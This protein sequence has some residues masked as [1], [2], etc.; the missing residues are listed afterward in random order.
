VTP[1]SWGVPA[2]NLTTESKLFNAA[3]KMVTLVV[4][5]GVDKSFWQI[6][7]HDS[8]HVRH[9]EQ[10][11][12]AAALRELDLSKSQPDAVLVAVLD[13]DLDRI[14]GKLIA[15]EDVVWT[16]GHDLETTLLGLPVL[17]KLIRQFVDDEKLTVHVAP[18]SNETVRDRLFRHAD[19]MGRLRW[20]KV[21]KHPE[22]NTLVFRKND[23]KAG[24]AR[25][26]YDKAVDTNW[27]PSL[28]KVIDAVIAFSNVQE[29]K[30]RDLDSECTELGS[31]PQEQVCNGHDLVGF[32]NSW[33]RGITKGRIKDAEALTMFLFAA[34]E[35]VWIE[36]S[37][38]RT[39]HGHSHFG[40]ASCSST[41][42]LMGLGG[43]DAAV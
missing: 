36:V 12:R 21:A 29:L 18:W 11:G 23:T 30:G 20:L 26:D 33:L 6:Y 24:K 2:P 28:S 25:V 17:D 9:M 34:V 5:S 35:R 14:R 41:M 7:R 15:R 43:R 27:T 1:N 42:G 19:G 16:D 32:L 38:A 37:D 8:C 22:L 39:P 4:E 13:A 31:A 10:G 40:P 3:R